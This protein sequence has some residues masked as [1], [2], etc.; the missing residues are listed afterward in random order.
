M[1]KGYIIGHVTVTDPDGY[2]EY[3]RRDTPV[4]QAMGANFIVRG[5]QSET[6]EGEAHNRTVVIEF[7]SYEQARKAYFDPEYQEIAEIR[8]ACADSTIILVEGV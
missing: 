3:I 6:V 4:L 2:P 8:R 5:G 7:E 1:P